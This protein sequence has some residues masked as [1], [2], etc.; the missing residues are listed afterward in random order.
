MCGQSLLER[1]TVVKLPA[2]PRRLLLDRAAPS[3]ILPSLPRQWARQDLTRSLLQG[4]I[5]MS[6]S[7]RGSTFP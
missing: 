5:L 3:E 2:R 4:Q 1:L 6:G 7:A